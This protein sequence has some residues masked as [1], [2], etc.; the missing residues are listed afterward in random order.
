MKTYYKSFSIT[1]VINTDSD[2]SVELE[3]TK[4]EPKQIKAILVSVSAYAGNTIRGV[5]EREK[6][7]E[8][9]DYA[10]RTHVASGTNQ[11]PTVNGLIRIPLDHK[12]EVGDSFK[13]TLNNGG[14]ATDLYGSYEYEILPA[15]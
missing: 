11:Y 4:T 3:S 13:L 6:I 1:G 7:L 9:Y 14:T 12:I 10:L 15:V 5:I 2:P 8:I